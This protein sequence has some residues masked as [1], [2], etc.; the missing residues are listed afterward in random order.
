MVR[1]AV[2]DQDGKHLTPQSGR[3]AMDLLILVEQTRS[4]I[5]DSLMRVSTINGYW[6]SPIRASVKRLVCMLCYGR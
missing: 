3:T 5:R 1:L 4:V 6:N 2:L